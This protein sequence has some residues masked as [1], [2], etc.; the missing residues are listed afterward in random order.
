MPSLWWWCRQDV[1]DLSA[2]VLDVALNKESVALRDLD[3]MLSGQKEIRRRSG[4]GQD[5]RDPAGRGSHDAQLCEHENCRQ[6]AGS[7]AAQLRSPGPLW[8]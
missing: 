2:A 4:V 6:C 5:A 8:P 1:N 7:A 3:D